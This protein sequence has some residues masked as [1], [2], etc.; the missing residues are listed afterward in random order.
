MSSNGKSD[1]SLAQLPEPA[2]TTIDAW[3]EILGELLAKEKHGLERERA[4]IMAQFAQAVAE[5]RAQIVEM[6]AVVDVA[7]ERCLEEMAER[8]AE[9]LAVV[10]DGEPGPPGPVGR[11]GLVGQIG[12][13]GNDGQQ[14]SEGPP[15]RDGTSI[16]VGKG[17]PTMQAEVDAIYID[18]ETGDLYQF[19]S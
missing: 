6:K 13:K 2:D 18:A 19:K 14:G 7:V 10:R 12:E 11:A 3:H 16:K 1:E 8:V 15:G 4:V 9:R 5:F 17:P